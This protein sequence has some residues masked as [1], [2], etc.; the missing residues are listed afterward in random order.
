MAMTTNQFNWDADAW[1]SGLEIF[2][3]E[4]KEHAIQGHVFEAKFVLSDIQVTAGTFTEDDIKKELANK[5]VYEL[6]KSKHIEF[7]KVPDLMNSSHVFRARI[8][9]VPDTHV[10]ILRENKVI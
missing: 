2:D 3:D 10:R 5:L 8:F 9:A 6:I 7:T 4:S 1:L